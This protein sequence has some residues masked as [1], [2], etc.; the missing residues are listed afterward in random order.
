[1]P[2]DI[3]K[4]SN[5]GAAILVS[6]CNNHMEYTTMQ[7]VNGHFAC[8]VTTFVGSDKDFVREF[9]FAYKQIGNTVESLLAN[10]P[11]IM[12]RYT[13]PTVRRPVGFLADRYMAE[14]EKQTEEE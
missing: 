6:A 8:Y 14:Q 2:Q 5:E 12:K 9:N 13:A 4:L 11:A 10:Y 7:F 1:M 3:D